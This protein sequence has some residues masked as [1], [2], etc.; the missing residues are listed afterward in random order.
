[1]RRR[2]GR[3]PRPGHVAF[4]DA[5][6]GGDQPRRRHHRDRQPALPLTRPPLRD[7]RGRAEGRPDRLRRPADR[8]RRGAFPRH[9]R[10]GRDR[11]GNPLMSENGAAP[12]R[13]AD[14]LA[15]E[16]SPLAGA[17]LTLI[18]LIAIAAHVYGWHITKI[19]LLE[20]VTGLPNMRHIV[21]GLV[22]PDVVERVV[23]TAT[24]EVP[25][26]LGC[27]DRASRSANVQLGG[28]AAPLQASPASAPPP[29]A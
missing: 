24:A 21:L 2:A 20:L 27:A 28:Q 10:G 12:K 15:V 26:G 16:R 8:D 14:P 23:E 11:G 22:Q 29:P 3:Q 13:L 19:N 25:F 5:L 9:L 1:A 6:P 7:P 18:I 17:R 4:G